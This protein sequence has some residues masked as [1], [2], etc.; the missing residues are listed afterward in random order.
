M[1]RLVRSVSVVLLSFFAGCHDSTGPIAL[2]LTLNR[3]RWQSQNLHDYSYTG[4]KICFCRPAGEV[5]VIVQADTVLS[6][7]L[8]G[9][10]EELPKGEWLTIDQLFDFA[11][12]SYGE[13]YESV[14][15]EYHPELG[16]PTLIVLT[17]PPDILDCGTTI[18]IKNL[19]SLAY[20]N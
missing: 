17:C 2:S 14:M 1:P 7:K 3:A 9:T 8:V 15:V 4:L 5:E 13:N 16:H 19:G 6:A 18:E 10:T 20:L 11:Q 12:R